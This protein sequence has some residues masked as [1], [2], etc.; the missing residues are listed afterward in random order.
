MVRQQ[1]QRDRRG[2]AGRVHLDIVPTGS[3]ERVD[4]AG[5]RLQVGGRAHYTGVVFEQYRRECGDAG[6]DASV[7]LIQNVGHRDDVVRREAAF[8]TTVESVTRRL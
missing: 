8:M 4:A 7:E 5:Q 3:P 1:R 2:R 6:E